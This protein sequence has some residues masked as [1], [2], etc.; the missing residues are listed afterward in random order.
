MLPRHAPRL[1]R[2]TWQQGSAVWWP[3]LEM[4]MSGSESRGL[5]G[6]GGRSA[7]SAAAMPA[8]SC[9]RI[10]ATAA[11]MEPPVCVQ[12]AVSSADTKDQAFAEAF[13]LLGIRERTTQA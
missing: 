7:V 1:Q 4:T 5:S 9:V 2:R 6:G 10:S 13:A 12:Q 11:S 8:R 3:A